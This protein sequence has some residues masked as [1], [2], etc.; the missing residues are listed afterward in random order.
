MIIKQIMEALSKLDP[1][2]TAYF[3]QTDKTDLYWITDL[4]ID[5]DGDVI[6]KEYDF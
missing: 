5:D 6:F 1:D 2:S 4:V 3:Q